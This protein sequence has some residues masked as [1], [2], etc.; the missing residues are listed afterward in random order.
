MTGSPVRPAAAE[1]DAPTKFWFTEM[2]RRRVFRAVAIYGAF[3][4]GVVEVANN[5]FPHLPVPA[6]AMSAVLWTV[7]IGFPIAVVLAWVFEMTWSGIQ[8]T[9]AA[10]PEDLAAMARGPAFARWSPGVLALGGL[11]LLGVGFYSGTRAGLASLG[12]P[13]ESTTNPASG[14]GPTYLALSEDPRPAIAVLPFDDMSPAGDQAYFSDGISAEVVTVLSKIREL[15]VAARSSAFTYRAK[16]LD[17]RQVGDELGVPYIL[18]GDVR[19]DGNQVRISAALVSVS[20]G[21]VVWSETYE[22]RLDNIFQIQ[23]DIAQSIAGSLRIPLGLDPAELVSSTLNMEAHDLYLSGRAA[24]RRRGPGVGEALRLFEA[25]VAMDSTWA[26]AW[27]ALAEGHAMHPLY[28]GEGGES[29][30]SVVWARA[31]E[32]SRA[33]ARRALALDP[34]N[35]SAR[36]ALGSSHSQKWEWEEAERELRRALD[37][38]PDNAEGHIQYAELLWGMGRLDESMRETGRA[39]ALDRAPIALNVHAF[40]LMM[41]GYAEEG[42]ALLEEALAL[43]EAGEV[44]YIRQMLAEAFLLDGRFKEALDRFDGYLNAGYRQMGEALAKGD[45]TLLPERGG[46]G[47]LSALVLLGEHERALDEIQELVFS[48]PF[49]V[50]YPIWHPVL[51]PIWDTPRF[52]NVILHQVRLAGASP[53]FE[54]PPENR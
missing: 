40:T 16:D 46:R 15:R 50:P 48:L 41:N 35:A 12:P 4:L 3:S 32:A 19:R 43:D 1:R 17:L 24:L 8:R 53:T 10:T 38:D 11:V 52:R 45:A 22:R 14:R 47:Y 6:W 44:H 34:R 28:T 18:D 5:F 49:R 29:R 26:P 7:A 20:D 51:A 9:E 37:L 27:A 13:S 21:F 25:A 54:I 23:S 42:E 2:R 30:D 31:L 36:V 33:A 39:L